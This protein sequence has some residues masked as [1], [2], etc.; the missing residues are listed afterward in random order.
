MEIGQPLHIRLA[1]PLVAL[2]KLSGKLLLDRFGTCPRVQPLPIG[3]EL[4][5]EISQDGKR[6]LKLRQKFV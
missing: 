6:G 1:L 3:L 2:L 4:H 5:L